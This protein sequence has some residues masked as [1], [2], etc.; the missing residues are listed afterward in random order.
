VAQDEIPQAAILWLTLGTSQAHP[1]ASGWPEESARLTGN[2][3]VGRH[4][5]PPYSFSSV[6]IVFVATGFASAENSQPPI[7]LKCS[8]SL[9]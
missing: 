2:P 9:E 4:E 6:V 5:G 1:Q 8:P 7:C 3:E